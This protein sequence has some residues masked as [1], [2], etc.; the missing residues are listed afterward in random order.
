MNVVFH[1]VIRSLAI[2]VAANLVPG[3]TL[4]GPMAALIVA[5][6]LGLLN[7]FVKPV[8]LVLTLPVNVMTLGLFTFVINTLLILLADRLVPGF[9]VASFW[10]A[11]WFGILL[12]VVNAFLNNVG[13]KL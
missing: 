10:T 7:M 4:E 6:V 11:M 2:W 12:F 1:L 9:A 8:L 13:K 3:V 5:V